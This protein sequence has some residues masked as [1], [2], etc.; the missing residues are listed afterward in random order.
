MKNLLLITAVICCT[1]QTIS[2]QVSDSLT[3]RLQEIASTHKIPGFGVS[4]VSKD[5]ILYKNG[6]GYADL[7][8]KKPFTD[9]TLLNIGSNTKTSIAFALMKLIEENK[10]SLEDPIN[11]HLPFEINH[12]KFPDQVIK[13]KHLAT[14]TS[15]LTDGE[16]SMVIENS[17]L[18]KGPIDF[19]KE[20]LP[21]DY[22][23]YF[24][25]YRKNVPMS[26]YEFLKNSYCPEGKWYDDANFL[27]VAPGHA[28]EYTNIG[29]TLLAFIIEQVTGTSF[30]DY[31]QQILWKPLSMENTHWYM[32]KVPKEKM[33]SLYLSNGLKIPHYQLI[34]YPDGGL[35]TNVSDFSLYLMEMIK[36]M[37]GDGTLLEESS[38]KKMMSNQLT[39]ENFP[40]G[41]FERS[42]GF[43]WDVN[44]EGDNIGM[45]G[46]DPGIFTYT[47]FT[48]AGNMG[49]IVF[50]NTSIYEEDEL[51]NG[52]KEIRRAL[53][54][55]ASKLSK[56]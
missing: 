23:P 44:P 29:A 22:D 36:G 45:N 46:A 49:I 19:K 20:Q 54:Q 27:E 56:Q 14:H 25:I 32:D 10:I 18:F 34:T 6:F 7:E 1:F 16:E 13:V 55:N 41:E 51:L 28:Y 2:Q 9:E 21:E 4:V 37:S 11:K 3:L 43:M 48:T 53:L 38:Y 47:L 35:I 17:Y 15:S 12:P 31:T 40:N 5:G 50:F 24:A 42:E 39:K 30:S 26:I 33:A 52:F 8:T